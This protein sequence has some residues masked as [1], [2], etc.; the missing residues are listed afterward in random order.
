MQGSIK[1]L[2]MDAAFS[3]TGLVVATYDYQVN[4]LTIDDMVLIQTEADKAGKKVI[5]KNSDDVRRAGEIVKALD[6]VID[7]HQPS[8]CMV[9]VPSGAQSAR[10][11]WALGIAVGCIGFVQSRIPLVQVTPKEVKEVVGVKFPDKAQMIEWAV[12]AYPNAPWPMRGGKIVA[13]K[14]EHL[15]DAVAAIHAGINTDDFKRS[16]AMLRVMR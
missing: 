14:A 5:R 9:E 15:A 1:L 7:L 2:G 8:M 16:M 12:A 6:I 3:N 4:L 11:S 10:A 13:G